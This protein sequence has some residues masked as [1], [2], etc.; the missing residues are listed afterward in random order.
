MRRNDPCTSRLGTI[1]LGVFERMDTSII[2]TTGGADIVPMMMS[3]VALPVICLIAGFLLGRRGKRKYENELL[4]ARHQ[5]TRFE[6]QNKD[7]NRVVARMREEL[8]TVA[9]LA[10]SLPH[11]VRDL[12]RDDLEPR[13]VPRLILQ[14]ANSIFRPEQILLY[15]VRST[16]RDNGQGELWLQ[17]QQGFQE[18]PAALKSIRIGEGKIGWVANYEIDMVAED[19]DN[20]ARTEGATVPANHPSLRADIMGPLLHHTLD[21]QAVLGVIC[22][23][24]P[25]IRVRDEK[26]MFQLVTNLA[27]LAL[28][29]CRNMHLLRSMANH[30]GLTSLLNKRYFIQALLPATL[31]NCEK[32]AQR[33][34]LFIFDIDHFKNYNDTNGH[35]AGDDLLR[36]MSQIIQS[37]LRPGDLACRYGGEEFIIAMPETDQETAT[38][39]AEKL[40]RTIEETKLLHGEHQPGGKVTISG[41]V[42]SFPQDGTSVSELIQHADEALYKSKKGGRNRVTVYEGVN[43]GDFSDP[44][45]GVD[46]PASHEIASER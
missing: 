5:M 31:I 33:L 46:L 7:Q 19:W 38:A 27:S 20:R 18:I 3:G 43:I 23:G 24:A 40:R 2:D 42:A 44:T 34:S 45:Q 11:I 28:V 15:G 32:D 6:S 10:L 16:A 36:H 29:N 4:Q 39:Q 8:D 26:L 41:G 9:S 22:L 13:E 17:A 1:R 21:S 37:S 12:N 30:D 25:R 14:L 35:P